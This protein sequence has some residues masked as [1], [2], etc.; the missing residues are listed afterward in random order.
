MTFATAVLG[1]NCT[2]PLV[3]RLPAASRSQNGWMWAGAS[4]VK[5]RRQFGTGI[6]VFQQLPNLLEVKS[7]IFQMLEFCGSLGA[8][9]SSP[10]DAGCPLGK[11]PQSSQAVP[12]NR[13]AGI[14]PGPFCLGL[15]RV[16]PERRR[17]ARRISLNLKAIH[18]GN[19]FTLSCP[20]NSSLPGWWI[21]LS[22]LTRR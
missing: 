13:H 1:G 15:R 19:G 14:R 11:V 16:S 18:N 10:P 4:V 5:A 3:S 8:G 6:V 17:L 12:Q 9:M 2:F 7:S 22:L 21:W 20:D